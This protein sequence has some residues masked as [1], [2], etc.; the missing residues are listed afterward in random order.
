MLVKRILLY[1]SYNYMDANELDSS[2]VEKDLGI[3]V[4]NK[5]KF[6]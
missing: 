2:G 3:L 6:D 4:E 1:S 5:L